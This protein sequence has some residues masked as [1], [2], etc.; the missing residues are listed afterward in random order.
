MRNRLDRALV[1]TVL[2]LGLAACASSGKPAL[3]ANSAEFFRTARLIMTGAEQDIFEHLPDAASRREFIEDFWARR[4][5]DPTSDVNSFRQ[6]FERRIEY[7]DKHFAEGRKG[8]DTDRG[9]IYVFLGSPDRV[10][11][12]PF[13]QAM[14]LLDQPDAI[15]GP[16]LWWVYY[17]YELGISFADY[18]NNGVYKMT[19]IE[20]NLMEAVEQAKL[21][22]LA[23]ADSG[24][25]M[26]FILK[27]DR[28]RK[29]FILKIP[30]KSLDFKEEK[31]RLSVGFTIDLL[32]YEPGRTKER[33][34]E[35]R[36]FSGTPEEVQALTNLTFEWAYD[37]PP[38]KSYMDVILIR[39]GGLSKARR[40]FMVK[41]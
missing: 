33:W 2:A 38:G 15:H 26:D 34:T 24:R 5:P 21:G 20:G 7:A 22:A 28:S 8:S 11:D 18:R 12:F 25:P 10:E 17:R 29:A 40:I 23:S 31:G 14:S 36:T 1:L 3:D 39:D 27:Y 19:E 30:I 16:I 32:I 9:R 35:D 6:E 13:H 4:N 41:N 37:L